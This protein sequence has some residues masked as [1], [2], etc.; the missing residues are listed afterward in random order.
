MAEA[1]LNPTQEATVCRQMISSVASQ[2]S[3]LD[4]ALTTSV[5]DREQYLLK[6]GRAQALREAT[7]ELEHIYARN[8]E[9]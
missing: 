2:L 6:M 4:E 5:L 7:R 3:A 8:F 9:T 1:L